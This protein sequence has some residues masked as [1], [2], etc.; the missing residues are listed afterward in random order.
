MTNNPAEAEQQSP[1][2][3]KKRPHKKSST[4]VV[5]QSVETH[6][7]KKAQRHMITPHLQSTNVKIALQK[8]KSKRM[9]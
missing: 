2:L 8:E 1:A 5:G 9:I 3:N 7:V 4:V 6:A